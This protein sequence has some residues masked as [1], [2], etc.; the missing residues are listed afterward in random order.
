MNTQA[1]LSWD[2]QAPIASL[3]TPCHMR[4][5]PGLGEQSKSLTLASSECSKSLVNLG[6]RFGKLISKKVTVCF[7]L[8][9]MDIRGQQG[10]AA[11]MKRRS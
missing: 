3:L 7:C 9:A 8:K 11:L 10:L 2:P 6:L 5:G 1:P 4:R